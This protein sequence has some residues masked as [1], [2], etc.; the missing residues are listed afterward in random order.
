MSGCHQQVRVPSASQEELMSYMEDATCAVDLSN[1][2]ASSGCGE[3]GKV[4]DEPELPWIK[5]ELLIG[6]TKPTLPPPKN[7]LNLLMRGIVVAGV[8]LGLVLLSWS[9]PSQVSMCNGVQWHGGL[10]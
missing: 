6:R 4:P 5:T 9:S 1:P 3:A 7:I 8:A 10:T 2:S